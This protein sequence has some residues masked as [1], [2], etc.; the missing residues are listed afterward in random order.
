M[1]SLKIKPIFLLIIVSTQIA[2][3]MRNIL[4]WVIYPKFDS[5]LNSFFPRA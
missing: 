3:I 2:H 4:M 1:S 5:D